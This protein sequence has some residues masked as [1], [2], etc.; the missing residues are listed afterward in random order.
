[1]KMIEKRNKVILY[2]LLT[3]GAVLFLMPIWTVLVISFTSEGKVYTSGSAL[4]PRQP[5]L[6]NYQR[7]F[8]AYPFVDW[9]RNS[10]IVTSL[11]TLG[12]FIS[13][14]FTAYAL[15]HFKYKGRELILGFL[16][17]NMMLPFQVQMVPLFLVMTKLK[18]VNTIWSLVV[19]AFF[20]DVTG[21]VCIFLLR[22]AFLQ[23][24]ASLSDAAYVDGANP[25]QVF[26]K[27]YLPLTKPYLAVMVL[28][29]FM[30]S[31]ND[32][33]RPLV[34]ISDINRMTV[35]GGLSFFRTEWQID[36]S[37]TMTGTLMAILPCVFLYVFLQKYFEK[38]VISSG[39]KG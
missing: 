31:W 17:A 15:T 7:I 22:Q 10:A 16:L 27:V 25:F 32:F 12:Q 18:L 36:W 38:M 9:F 39:V 14:T 28:L 24:P 11:Y 21:A 30:T 29:S 19:P 13:C 26:T 1:M 8:E 4:W 35:T 37:L 20:G 2:I 5:T 6:E 34:Y 33:S 3:I 23:V